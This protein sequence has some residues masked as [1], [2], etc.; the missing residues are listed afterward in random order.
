MLFIDISEAGMKPD[1]ISFSAAISVCNKG[2]QWEQ[3][4]SLLTE[5]CQTMVSQNVLTS[6]GYGSGVWGSN[7]LRGLGIYESMDLRGLGFRGLGI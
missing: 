2:G 3:A 7:G 4:L 5:L 1:T 6:R